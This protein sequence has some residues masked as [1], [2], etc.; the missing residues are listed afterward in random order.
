MVL[1][2]NTRKNS[3]QQKHKAIFETSSLSTPTGVNW[4]TW[5]KFLEDM[6]H[7]KTNTAASLKSLDSSQCERKTLRWTMTHIRFR[8]FQETLSFWLVFS[9]FKVKKSTLPFEKVHFSSASAISNVTNCRKA[10]ESNASSSLKPQTSHSSSLSEADSEPNASSN[11]TKNSHKE[12]CSWPL[13]PKS[14]P[15]SHPEST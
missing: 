13:S 3:E 1:L 5:I 4:L 10:W 12:I 6:S 2:F 9:T 7:L 15:T 8:N 11:P 14:T